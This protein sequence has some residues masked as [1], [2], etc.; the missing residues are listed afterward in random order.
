MKDPVTFGNVTVKPGQVGHG[1]LTSVELTD[2]TKV[3]LPIIVVNGAMNGPRFLISGAVHGGELIGYPVILRLI[4]EEIDPKKLRGLIVAIP[5]GNPLGFHFGDRASPQ[6]YVTGPRFG[7]PGNPNGSITERLGAA[8]WDQVTS[9]MDLRV[10]IHGNYP[11]CTAFCLCSQH[12]PRIRGKNDEI[13]KASGLTVVYSPPRGTLVG[14]GGALDESFLPPPSVTFE[15]IDA[16]RITD[17]SVDLGVRGLMNIMK[18]WNMVDGEIEPQPKDYVWGN[19]RVQNAGML[20][21]NRGGLIYFT[22][23]PGEHVKK[24][25]IIARI[26]NPYGEVLEE[27]EFPHDGFIRSYTYLKHQAVNGG[28]TI[29]YITHDK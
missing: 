8:V 26:F 22:K 4:N 7:Q 9:K 1:V 28:D 6:D 24:G 16:R 23:T 27:I 17:V 25:E 13:A 10:D 15:L 5:I 11:P 20:R 12:D 21:C 19:G 29:A 2:S 14:M 3:N 18:T